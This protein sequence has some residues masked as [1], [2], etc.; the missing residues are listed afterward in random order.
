M[1]SKSSGKIVRCWRQ[2]GACVEGEAK[3]LCEHTS[4]SHI[5]ALNVMMGVIDIVADW[6]FLKK[7]E[8]QANKESGRGNWGDVE[9]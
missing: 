2:C 8:I 4:T 7:I 1:A 6:K 5:P 3:R 9:G